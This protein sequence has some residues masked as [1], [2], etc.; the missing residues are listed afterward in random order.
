M[1][2]VMEKNFNNKYL[3]LKFIFHKNNLFS[4]ENGK[5]HHYLEKINNKYIHFWFII[6]AAIMNSLRVAA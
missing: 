1:S 4:L 3:F 5:K 2:R 6:A